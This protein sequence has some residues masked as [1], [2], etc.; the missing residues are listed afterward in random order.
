M[1]ELLDRDEAM[2]R[3]IVRAVIVERERCAAVALETLS[4]LPGSDP[5]LSI[6]V[7]AA[8]QKDPL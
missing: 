7:A 8:I 6:K 4:R 2:R 3:A 5:F 1:S